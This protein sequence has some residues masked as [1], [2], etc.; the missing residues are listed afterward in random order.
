M[1]R[2][3][4]VGK[5]I[6]SNSLL[7]LLY[8]NAVT[9]FRARLDLPILCCCYPKYIR[10]FVATKMASNSLLLLHKPYVSG[11]MS[12]AHFQFFV[13]VTGRLL[14][15]HGYR[16]YPPSNSLLL[17]HNAANIINQRPINNFQFFVV[18]TYDNE[19]VELH[20]LYY[21]PILCCCY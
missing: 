1:R 9:T 15:G 4:V 16:P 14:A 11:W 19:P 20:E 5:I 13:V 2:V 12:R 18:V 21:L 6:S 10:K 7:L 17:L 3:G 8:M